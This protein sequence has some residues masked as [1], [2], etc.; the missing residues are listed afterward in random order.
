MYNFNLENDKIYELANNSTNIKYL[1]YERN[2]TIIYLLFMYILLD[3]KSY[4]YMFISTFL[5]NT[6][7]KINNIKYN[8]YEILIK[9]RLLNESLSNI[10]YNI[11]NIQ[12]I[13]DYNLELEYSLTGTYTNQYIHNDIIMNKPKNEK[14]TSYLIKLKIK[15][16]KNNKI[17]EYLLNTDNTNLTFEDIIFNNNN[18]IKDNDIN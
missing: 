6:I 18:I 7:S 10:Q 1:L 15:L 13:D 4:N 12:I 8:I 5:K 17:C 3:T 16:D 14:L 9:L 2:L 11:N